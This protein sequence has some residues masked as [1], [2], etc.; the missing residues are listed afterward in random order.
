MVCLCCGPECNKTCTNTWRDYCCCQ[1]GCCSEYCAKVSLTKLINSTQKK[2]AA[3][4]CCDCCDSCYH[5]IGPRYSGCKLLC[6]H[7]SVIGCPAG[8]EKYVCYFVETVHSCL[9][10]Q[11]ERLMMDGD[12]VPI[13]KE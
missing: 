9:C 10:C 13:R 11:E 5:C 12:L 1:K 2:M 4:E 7:C 8:C 3:N 6:C